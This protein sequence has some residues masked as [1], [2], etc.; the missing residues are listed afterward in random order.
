MAMKR[1]KEID[2]RCILEAEPTGLGVWVVGCEVGKEMRIMNVQSP[3]DA[4]AC[5]GGC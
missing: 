4:S 1:G 3:P 5:I 2:S